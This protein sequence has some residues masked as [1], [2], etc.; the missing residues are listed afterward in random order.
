MV[1][2]EP[3]SQRDRHV[4]LTRLHFFF[5]ICSMYV[6]LVIHHHGVVEQDGQWSAGQ[7]KWNRK[8]VPQLD[9]HLHHL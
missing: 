5:L 9:Y 3:L 4:L 1:D 8:W 2:I 6:S 7:D